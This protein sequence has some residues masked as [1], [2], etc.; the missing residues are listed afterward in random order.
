[1]CHKTAGLVANALE[2]AGIATVVIGTMHKPL[3]DVPRAVHTP[4]INAPIGPPG[5]KQIQR[6]V[7]EHALHLL[8]FATVH[9]VETLQRNEVKP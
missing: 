9:T 2:F 6:N 1:M 3:E 4:F 5:D 8:T 7:I